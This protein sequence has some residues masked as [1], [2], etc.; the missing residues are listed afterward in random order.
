MTSQ[1]VTGALIV[2]I[3]RRRTQDATLDH[4]DRVSQYTSGQFQRLVADNDVIGSMSRSVDVWYN[5][6]Q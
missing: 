6:A 2:A 3:W 1:F 4:F 5:A